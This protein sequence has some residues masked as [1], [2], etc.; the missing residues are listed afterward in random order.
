L[1][2]DDEEL[3]DLEDADLYEAPPPNKQTS[4]EEFNYKEHP[5][6]EHALDEEG[7]TSPRKV[8]KEEA[9]E[10]G[11]QSLKEEQELPHDSIEDNEEAPHEDEM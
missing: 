11:Y 4:D 6:L 5:C 1:N 8:P 3:D 10:E 2:V 9:Y 7:F